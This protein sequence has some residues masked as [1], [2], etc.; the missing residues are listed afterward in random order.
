MTKDNFPAASERHDTSADSYREQAREVTTVMGS[1]CGRLAPSTYRFIPFVIV[2]FC[3]DLC[4]FV[5]VG[6]W[7]TIFF[8]ITRSNDTLNLQSDAFLRP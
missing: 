5:G 8:V 1:Y 7:S 4:G 2:T 3:H 6:F